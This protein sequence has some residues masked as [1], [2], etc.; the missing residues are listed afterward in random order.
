MT[1]QFCHPCYETNLSLELPGQTPDRKEYKRAMG[2]VETLIQSLQAAVTVAD[3]KEIGG[4]C[5]K[6][7]VIMMTPTKEDVRCVSVVVPECFT[8]VL[9]T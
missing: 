1:V 5:L 9:Q 3:G 7:G 4:C 6:L 8:G 2:Q